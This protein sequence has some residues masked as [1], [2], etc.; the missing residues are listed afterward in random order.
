MIDIIF[1]YYL[2]FLFIF[3]ILIRTIFIV[4]AGNVAVITTFGRVTGEP[5]YPGI[6]FIIPFVQR[7]HTFN[8]KTQVIPEKFTSLTRDLQ[9]IQATATIKYSVKAEKAGIIFQNI[10]YTNQEIYPKIVQPSLLRALKSVFTQYELITIASEWDN[11]STI[12]KEDV[13]KELAEFNY[14]EVKNL[15]LTG[16]SIAEEYREAIE[17]KQIAEQL[18]LKAKTEVKI[19]EQE[20]IRYNILSN[21][22]EDKVLYKLFL[23]KW[24]GQTSIVPD[25]FNK[26]DKKETSI[27]VDNKNN[28]N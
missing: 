6:H 10:A 16:L 14:V 19:S 7:Y 5:K 13:A 15:D 27:I 17:Q 26:G 24:N 25:I 11:I 4:Q 2:I 21:S 1:R 18:L 8:V 3:I 20:A 9:V 28:N 23:D 12:V 22:L